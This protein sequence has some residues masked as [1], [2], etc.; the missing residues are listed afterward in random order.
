M[1]SINFYIFFFVE[2]PR[3]SKHREYHERK[4]KGGRKGK[5]AFYADLVYE[6][7]EKWQRGK[8]VANR[9]YFELH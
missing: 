6:M 1:K 2:L 4:Q 5:C 3:D 8:L 7:E 9:K